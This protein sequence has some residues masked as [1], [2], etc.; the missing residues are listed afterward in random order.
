[1]TERKTLGETDESNYEGGDEN[2]SHGLKVAKT[3]AHK[4][5]LSSPIST[6]LMVFIGIIFITQNMETDGR[7]GHPE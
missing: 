4:T 3:S 5:I 1:L 2:N 6:Q 7:A